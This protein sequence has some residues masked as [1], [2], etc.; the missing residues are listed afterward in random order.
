MSELVHQ[1]I[2][3]QLGRFWCQMLPFP[4]S[5]LTSIQVK[6]LGHYKVAV[7]VILAE[8]QGMKS[9]RHPQEVRDGVLGL[10]VSDHPHNTEIRDWVSVG[11]VG[12]Q[13][14]WQSPP[15]FMGPRVLVARPTQMWINL[16]MTRPN[17][18]TRAFTLQHDDL[19]LGW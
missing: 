9:P 16:R 1:D 5:N 8:L 11:V 17:R 18:A 4:V 15:R 6:G 3:R 10:W 12:S 19:Y 2:H 7:V 14:C 13:A